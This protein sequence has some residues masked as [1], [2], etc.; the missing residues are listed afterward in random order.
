MLLVGIGT[1]HSV[2]TQMAGKGV[3]PV[4]LESWRISPS[5]RGKAL[6]MPTGWVRI[7]DALPN[8][9]EEYPSRL[10]GASYKRVDVS[11]SLTSST[12]N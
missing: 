12:T 8:I 11:S 10:R 2:G 6:K 3:G 4:K 7:P 1:L 5:G 9:V